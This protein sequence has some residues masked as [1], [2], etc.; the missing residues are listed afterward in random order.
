[1]S[2]KT[3][4]ILKSMLS[5]HLHSKGLTKNQI[6]KALF[7]VFLVNNHTGQMLSEKRIE[8]YLEGQQGVN[9][10]RTSVKKTPIK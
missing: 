4:T 8:E 9:K 1:M 2:S 3:E 10:Q 5:Q 7:N 6:A